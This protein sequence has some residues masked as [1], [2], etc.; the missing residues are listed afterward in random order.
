MQQPKF[1]NTYR[2]LL[3]RWTELG[4]RPS[5]TL[6]EQQEYE[7]ADRFLAAREVGTLRP[8]PF[9]KLRGTSGQALRELVSDYDQLM[10]LYEAG[11][12]GVCEP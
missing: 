9:D 12:L 2:T 5:R 11:N 4:S 6:S 1:D 8:C 3:R 10:Q 7:A